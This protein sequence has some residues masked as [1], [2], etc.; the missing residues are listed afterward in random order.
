MSEFV[1]EGPVAHDVA[2]HET[3]PLHDTEAVMLE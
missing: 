1:P 3:V 2:V